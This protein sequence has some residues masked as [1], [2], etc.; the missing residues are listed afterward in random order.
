[1]PWQVWPAIDAPLVRRELG[2]E[3]TWYETAKCFYCGRGF[4]AGDIYDTGAYTG[5]PFHRVCWSKPLP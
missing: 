2:A 4:K 3:A 1:V 5:R